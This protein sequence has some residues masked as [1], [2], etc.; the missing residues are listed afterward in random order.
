MITLTINQT[1]SL[2]FAAGVSFPNAPTW[3]SNDITI[4]TVLATG[5]GGALGLTATVT[6]VNIG[7]T[8][9][10]VSGIS[11]AGITYNAGITVTVVTSA[12]I[13]VSIVPGVPS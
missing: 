10:S 12:P 5:Q 3:V 1:V 6:P 13:T 4:A 7:S 2:F 9:V 11:N 8:V